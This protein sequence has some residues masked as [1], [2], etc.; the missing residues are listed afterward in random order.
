MV[1]AEEIR[2]IFREEIANLNINKLITDKIEEYKNDLE[3]NIAGFVEK[4]VK[5]KL[6][7]FLPLIEIQLRK[8]QQAIDRQERELLELQIFTRKRNLLIGG[9]PERENEST[10][11]LT[12]D[13][14]NMFQTNMKISEPIVKS[15]VFTAIHRMGN[16]VAGK[17][18]V[19]VLV[20]LRLHHVDAVLSQGKQLKDTAFT[21][22]SHLPQP[23]AKYRTAIVNK[24]KDMLLEDSGRYVR[25]IEQKGIPVLLTK[26]DRAARQWTTLESY[27]D[28]PDTRAIIP[29]NTHLGMLGRFLADLAEL[30]D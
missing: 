10:A 1:S 28:N 26:P 8:Q 9:I 29:E 16:R 13:V 19:V 23:L 15:M 4:S 17:D 25:V 24:R 14:L 30:D 2:Q 18:R 6:S 5:D 22:R 7:E 3:G 11:T 20:M 12:T 27:Y 21:V